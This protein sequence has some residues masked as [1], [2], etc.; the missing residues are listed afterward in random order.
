MLDLINGFVNLNTAPGGGGGGIYNDDDN[1]S[2]IGSRI[3]GNTA[4]N[5]SPAGSVDG[6]TG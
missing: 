2:V 1:I 4:S 3:F 5:C 6:C